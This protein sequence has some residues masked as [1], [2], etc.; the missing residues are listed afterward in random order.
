M[1][2]S[3]PMV[4]VQPVDGSASTEQIPLPAVFS[5]PLRS[6]IVVQVGTAVPYAAAGDGSHNINHSAL[7]MHSFCETLYT[8]I[9]KCV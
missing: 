6:D 3:R 5:A 9:R 7:G 8:L 1:A 4:T 2:A